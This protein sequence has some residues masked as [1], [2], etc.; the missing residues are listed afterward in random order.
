VPRRRATSTDRL[1]LALAA[2]TLVLGACAGADVIGPREPSQAARLI[3]DC[4][5]ADAS[6]WIDDRY[7][8]EVGLLGEGVAVAPGMRRIE[9]RH[10]HYH[11]FYARI[12][13]EPHE[14][15]R[16]EVYLARELP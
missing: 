13:F 12:A 3:L 6:V 8:G 9:V 1:R 4:E 16:L 5:V 2:L 11:T 14:R 7:V 10:D 15:K